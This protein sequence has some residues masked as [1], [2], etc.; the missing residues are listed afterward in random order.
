VVIVAAWFVLVGVALGA[1]L[2]YNASQAQPVQW[3][4]VVGFSLVAF[5][6]PLSFFFSWRSSR[7]KRINA[8][9][10]ARRAAIITISVGILAVLIPLALTAF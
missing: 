1:S 5:P 2:A 8:P 9:Q 10:S 6:C 4:W 7:S 3:G